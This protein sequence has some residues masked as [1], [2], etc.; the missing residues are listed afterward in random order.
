VSPPIVAPWATDA[1]VVLDGGLSNALE[2]RGADL[3]H[4]WWTARLLRDE[5]ALIV[6]AHR[7]FF[8]AGADVATTASY[9]ASLR[10]FMATGMSSGEA[11]TLLASSVHLARRARALAQDAATRPLLVAASIG[12]YG[13]ILADGS[14]YRGE[15]QVSAAVLRDFHGPRL[16]VLADAGPDLLA[17]ETIPDVREAE[18]LLPLLDEIGLPTWWSYTVDGDRTRAGQSLDEAFSAVA[19]C[20]AV[21]AAGVN[22]CAPSDVL[23]AVESAVAATGL[24]GVAYPNRGGR[25]DAVTDA[26][27]DGSG[28]AGL[29]DLAPAWIAAGARLIGGCCQVGVDEIGALAELVATHPTRSARRSRP[30]R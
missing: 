12:P 23:G 6:D 22:C 8:D 13:A 18:V 28:P 2:D 19:G 15:Y 11:E 25:W 21:V 1:V 29:T 9:Q 20:S 10:T 16:E 7:A 14:E 5:P 27:V 4:P 26:W 24:P 30:P 17:V 3:A